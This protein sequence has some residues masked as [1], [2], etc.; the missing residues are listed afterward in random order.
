MATLTFAAL[1]T[2]AHAD[3]LRCKAS[4]EPGADHYCDVNREDH[5]QGWVRA[6][7]RLDRET[8]K[9]AIET[10]LDT[11]N[12]LEGPCMKARIVLRDDTGAALGTVAMDKAVCRAGKAPG[13]HQ[14]SNY[15]FTRQVPVEIA[16]RTA[17]LDVQ[18][19]AAGHASTLPKITIA[20]VAKAIVFLGAL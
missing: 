3:S 13:K 14:H 1:A 20:D 12:L 7:A 18:A 19:I 8:G 5:S 16:R 6:R 11:D 10:Q 15:T 4:D 17:S 2:S 9:L